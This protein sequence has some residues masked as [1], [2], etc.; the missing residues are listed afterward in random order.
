MNNCIHLKKK[1]KKGQYFLYCSKDK[2]EINFEIC[3]SCE[4]KEYKIKKYKP[5]K[6][7]NK[8]NK[9]RQATSIPLEVKKIVWERDSHQ[10][11]FCHQEVELFFANSHF[12]KRS[13]S[14]LGIPENIFTACYLCHS[15][16]DDSP[17]RKEWMLK[18]AEDYMKNKYPKWNKDN[19]VYRKMGIRRS[20]YD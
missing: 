20:E 6:K 15:L 18:Y 2:K 5:M 14:G 7:I 8:Y 3:K 4:F 10:C 1:S 16:F 13:H 11:I 12:I 19:L 17:Q 9:L